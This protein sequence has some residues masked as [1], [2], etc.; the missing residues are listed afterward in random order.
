MA[1]AVL[2]AL[3]VPVV[4][5]PMAGGPSTPALAAAVSEAGGLGFLAAGYRP[6]DALSE[7]LAAVR[8]AT[9]R[10][11]GVNLFVPG[12]DR[13]DG[14]RLAGYA[15]RVR[16]EAAAYGAEA[17]E[18]RWG[19]DGWSEKLGVVL[20]QRPA[21]VS[22]AFGCPEPEVV[23]RLQRAGIEL[24][25]TVTEPAEA[26]QAARA[27]ADAL[28]VQGVEAGAHRG[29][30]GDADGAGELGLLALLRLVARTT[31]LPLVATGG[32]CD[33]DG[34]AAVLVAGARAA[35]LG[36]AF[37][38][39]REAGTSA[40][41]REALRGGRPT[42]LTRAFTG[43]R[44]RGIVNGFLSRNSAAAP[45]A[46]PNVHHLTAPLRAAA[47]ERGDA[48]MLNLWAGQAYTAIDHDVTAGKV[49]ERLAREIDE[50]L[51]RVGR[52]ASRQGG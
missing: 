3:R 38:A 17:G 15:E 43:R 46:Y 11:F 16:A 32:L 50:A 27:G 35:Q 7:D 6:A 49:V 26:E 2:D 34:V 14:A 33:G 36:T 22:L 8:A 18:P 41:H 40:A 29:S 5:A 28:V 20:E 13:A 51:L 48:E 9:S 45:S 31:E 47:R 24:W 23:S 4:Q 52:S 42:Q 19:D 21:V 30:F 10:P 25:V 1:S 37:L 12:P 44:A 39:T